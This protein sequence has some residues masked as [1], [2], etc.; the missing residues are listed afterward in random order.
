MQSLR[1]TRLFAAA[2]LAGSVALGAVAPAFADQTLLN[3]S[4]DPTRELYKDFNAAFR[5]E[6]EEGHR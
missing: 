4:Y 5:C 2:V 6:V 3:V 1:I